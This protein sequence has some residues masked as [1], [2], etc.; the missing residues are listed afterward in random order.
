MGNRIPLRWP[1]KSRRVAVTVEEL[2]TGTRGT[3]AIDLLN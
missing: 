2:K 3:A 1:R